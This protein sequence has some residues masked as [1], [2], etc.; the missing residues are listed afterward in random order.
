MSQTNPKVTNIALNANGGPFAVILLTILASKAEVTEDPAYNAGVGQSLQGYYLD[1]QVTLAADFLANPT[2][3]A[4]Q[5][6]GY[7]ANPN[8]QV[9]LPNN[10][11]SGQAQSYEPITFGG[12]DG[13][14]HGG[15]GGY[16]GAPGPGATPGSWTGGLLMLTMNS[17]SAGG[18][19]L[20]EWP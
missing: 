18:V 16:V 10:G 14:V 13:R 3:A 11:G 6:R 8:R 7:L 4:A 5:A 2:L 12:S 20:T 9:W 1:P 15:E 17:A 19:L